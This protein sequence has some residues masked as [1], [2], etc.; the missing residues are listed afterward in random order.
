MEV[1]DI[2]CLWVGRVVVCAVPVMICL[3][4]LFCLMFWVLER[5]FGRNRLKDNTEMLERVAGLM[6]SL[7]KE[8]EKKRVIMEEGKTKNCGTSPEPTEPK[9]EIKPPAQKP[10]QFIP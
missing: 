9:P 3:L 2:C 1:F 5:I 8:T 10:S 6:I 4:L 7:E